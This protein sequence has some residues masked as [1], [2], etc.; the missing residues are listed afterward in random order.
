MASLLADL[1]HQA[2]EADS[3][4][5]ALETLGAYGGDFDIMITDVRM[6]EMTG[7]SL[8]RKVRARW[9]NLAVV[10]ASGVDAGVT[11]PGL[12]LRKPF[13]LGSLER[14]VESATAH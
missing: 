2:I 14:A 10:F 12:K 4:T 13:S 8:A 6:P 1:G 3:G 7:Y 11:A 9:P 5:D